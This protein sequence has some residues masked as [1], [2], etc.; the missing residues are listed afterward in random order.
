MSV[1]RVIGPSVEWKYGLPTSQPGQ[2]DEE[3]E[4]ALLPVAETSIGSW[5]RDMPT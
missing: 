5:A 2:W 3:E 4:A 1:W